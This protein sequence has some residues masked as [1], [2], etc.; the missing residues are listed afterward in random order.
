[1][2]ELGLGERALYHAAS[3]FCSL[4]PSIQIALS[5]G[6]VVRDGQQL[7]P[8]L[9]MLMRLR[10]STGRRMETSMK[11][12][13]FRAEQNKDAR[14]AGGLPDGLA[15]RDITIEG[16]AGPLAAR[17]YPAAEA[18]APLLVF[19]HGGGFVFGDLD[20]HDAPC[21]VLRRYGNFHV[22]AVDYRLAPEHPFPAAVEDA[23]AALRWAH[24]H[25][26]RLGADPTRVGIGG[27][28]AGANLTAVVAQLAARDGGPAPACQLL[29]YPAIDRRTPWRSLEL[30]A[31]GFFLT[32]EAVEW[33]HE[34][35]A[36][37]H[38][39]DAR[40]NPLAN[41]ELSGLARALVVTAGFDPLRDEGEA[42]AS[43]LRECGND[44]TVRR[45][46]SLLH[47]F[48][49]MVGISRACH[50]AAVEIAGATRM[51]FQRSS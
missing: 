19:L 27:D 31:N 22:L 49:N 14:I 36:G 12:A 38:A 48:F 16:A 2:P 50:E 1:M 11:L 46:D 8:E 35:Y 9:A 4:P 17:H 24:A 25:A 34:Q 37:A 23:R 6:P 15:V 28:S 20:T 32:R 7:H 43:K 13:R 51:L 39:H 3:A 21:R 33:F 26:K 10:E 42:Y 5:G 44:V 47:G 45:F 30:F 41:Q 40:L 29:I 18:D